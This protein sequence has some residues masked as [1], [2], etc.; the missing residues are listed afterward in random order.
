MLKEFSQVEWKQCQTEIH[1]YKEKV[2]DTRNGKNVVK[3]LS[4]MNFFKTTGC[5]KIKQRQHKYI[6]GFIIHIESKYI[7]E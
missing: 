2:K 4:F 3:S 5:L 1:I 6:M 7:T